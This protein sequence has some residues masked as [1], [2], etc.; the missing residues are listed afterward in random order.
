MNDTLLVPITLEILLA[1]NALRGRDFFRTWRH[2]YAALRD[3]CSPEPMA[4]D[5]DIEDN[6]TGAFL[7]WTLPRSLRASQ[8][9]SSTAFPLVPNRWLINRVYPSAETATAVAPPNTKS[10]VVESDHLQNDAAKASYFLVGDDV[11]TNWNKGISADPVSS[12]GIVPP[13]SSPA[14]NAHPVNMGK[15]F[16]LDEWAEHTPLPPMFLTAIAPGNLEFSGYVPFNE[17]VFS[18]YD[19]L[20]GVPGDATL[21]YQVIG[22]YSD[23]H[24]DVVAAVPPQFTSTQKPGDRSAAVLAALNWQLPRLADGTLPPFPNLNLK[25]SLYHGTARK[26][27]WQTQPNAFSTPDELED[28]RNQQNLNVAM[29]NNSVDAFSTLVGTQLAVKGYEKAE[30]VIEL[31][32][33]FH[34]DLLPLLN[35]PNGSELLGE[36]IRQE[37]FSSRTGGTQ[38]AIVAEP[39]PAAPATNAQ[40]PA[41]PA[42][43]KVTLA[44]KEAKEA[45]EATWLQRLNI[46]QQEV[47]QLLIDLASQQ[48]ALHAAWWK[49]G[50]Y[51]A[52]NQPA[53]L[54]YVDQF[55][56][57]EQHLQ[58]QVLATLRS[59][60]EKL[61]KV[62]NVAQEP[63]DTQDADGNKQDQYLKAIKEFMERPAE[64]FPD[65]STLTDRGKTLKAVTQP[66]YWLPTNPSVVIS[67]VQ[68]SDITNPASSL[69]VRQA[70]PAGGG[71][72]PEK[73][74]KLPGALQAGVAQLYD[75]LLNPAAPAAASPPG[76]AKPT[77][78]TWR[79]QWHPMYLE[80]EVVYTDV[81]YVDSVTK[82]PN[83]QFNGTDYELRAGLR[84]VAAPQLISGRSLLS[85]NAQ[86]TFKARLKKFAEQYQSG[87]NDLQKICDEI[88]QIDD[89]KF[90]SQELVG[91]NEWLTQRD[92]RIFRAS[93]GEVCRDPNGQPVLDRNGQPLTLEK[94]LG[95]P[96]TSRTPGYDTPAA[97]QG[98]INSV[99]A[100]APTP[101]GRSAF[102]FHAVRSGQLYLNHLV[103]YDKFGRKLELVEPDMAGMLDANVFPLI[104]DAALLPSF[105]LMPD[106]EA[107]V[108]LPP[109]LLQPA[110]LDLLLIDQQDSRLAVGQG[111]GGQPVAGW[112]LANHLDQ[113]LL[114]F[115]P[116][117]SSLGEISVNHTG[118]GTPRWVAPP[119]PIDWLKD[120]DH[121]A[122]LAAIQSRFPRLGR[123]VTEL[124][125][126]KAADFATLLHVIDST[127][128]T[129]DPLGSRA[130][131]HLSV[132]VG[133]PLALVALQVQF[134]LYGSPLTGCDWLADDAGSSPLT[135]GAKFSVRLGNQAS[136]EDGVIGYFKTESSDIDYRTFHSVV[137][138]ADDEAYG[139]DQHYVR[140]IGPLASTDGNYLSLA[141]GSEA[142]TDITLLVDP[143]A[144]I[145]AT[146]GILPVKTLV[147]PQHF[148]HEALANME[149][150]FRVGPLLSR[151]KP[152][153]VSQAS[154][155]LATATTPATNPPG[156]GAAANLVEALSYLPM[157]EKN[158]T[159]RWWEKTSTS[160]PT[161]KSYELLNATTTADLSG[162]AT[163]LPAPAT[164]R[165]GYLQLRANLDDGPPE[166]FPEATED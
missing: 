19:D 162:G 90:L 79:Q 95:F 52:A 21:S 139:R 50:Y 9:G 47:N 144:T 121:A 114:I 87:E 49:K 36:H 71:P 76:A 37:W 69:P 5:C 83:W 24:Q 86:L 72:A 58:N 18:F 154:P 81:P 111:F 158:G 131:Q 129:V 70:Q 128:W 102:P 161:W 51:T 101:S 97:A 103:L 91:F 63:G 25:T 160:D 27:R 153:P 119:H 137:A 30:H 130:D 100:I 163:A 34:Y 88:G 16:A 92:T 62:P 104:R 125:G 116:D 20:E 6:R 140:Q 113:A 43:R 96:T 124:E 107:T 117:G 126:K 59:L 17:G 93:T 74:A 147:L 35:Q 44:E 60:T 38:W 68:P 157:S 84:G 42:P 149:I 123:F 110:R 115:A 136:R 40:A 22:W 67:Q 142:K 48:W 133:R 146:T 7:H 108:Q 148:V 145:H 159:W 3:F 77:P 127:L 156:A 65:G 55:D 46:A 11:L 165:E 56:S 151:I 23:A 73:F 61:T 106:V 45:E 94:I 132:L 13:G 32:R 138:P 109:R 112:L 31:L 164:L 28:T 12:A 98:L 8:P 99:P 15:A 134:S 89:W 10:W 143:R 4:F 78:T 155:S 41:K 29:A 57:D 85:P 141:V 39:R 152:V 120:L 1:N 82:Q 66:R 54:D 105:N 122:A 75:E 166:E 33:A 2:S 135:N 26:L 64:K 53:N 118:P 80:W 150:S 14:A